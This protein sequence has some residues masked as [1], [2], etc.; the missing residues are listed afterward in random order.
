MLTKHQRLPQQLLGCDGVVFGDNAYIRQRDNLLRL[1]EVR[2]LH[3][4]HDV[5]DEVGSLIGTQHFSANV[6]FVVGP[7]HVVALAY[8]YCAFEEVVTALCVEL[9]ASQ[10]NG[11]N[12]FVDRPILAK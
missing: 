5:R 7:L 11:F 2:F 10:F 4:L 12:V 3:L 9:L 6:V 8:V 1:I